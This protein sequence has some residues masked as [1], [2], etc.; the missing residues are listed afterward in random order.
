VG[1]GD[2]RRERA[3]W[4]A[5]LLD[6]VGGQ[7]AAIYV[8]QTGMSLE[9]VKA[10]MDAETWYTAQ[11]AVD[12]GFATASPCPDDDA[13]AAREALALF[14]FSVFEHTPDQVAALGGTR[15]AAAAAAEQHSRL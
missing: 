14:D 11:E 8:R 5:D 10:A 1:D 15:S 2:R 7:L 13:K 3:P 9:D 4:T 12:G 6:K